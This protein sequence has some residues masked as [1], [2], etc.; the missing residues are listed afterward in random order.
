M[1]AERL[2]PGATLY[3]DCF[4]GLSG[5]MTVAALV[6]LGVPVK[7]VE[8]AVA[9]LALPGVGVRFERVHRGALVGCK[10]RVDLPAAPS[11][12]EAASS[13]HEG[14][15][16]GAHHVGDHDHPTAGPHHHEADGHHPAGG[17]HH[18][19]D[20]P[21]RHYG[22][23]RSLLLGAPLGDGVRRRAL[24]IFDR[25]A[26]VEAHLHG[27]TVDEVAFHEVGALD[28]IVDIVAVAAA[29]DW[30]SPGRVVSRRVPLGHGTVET[31][32]GRLPIPA[33]ATLELLR[34]AAVEDGGV[35][36][37]LVT[38]TGAAILA[39][40]TDEY[41]QLPELTV[42]AVGWGAGD[43]ELADRPNLLR[44]LLGRAG[45]GG[46]ALLQLEANLDDLSPEL[47]APL[48]EALLAAGARDAWLQPVV[49]K[50]GR[51]GWIVGALVDAGHRAAA[52]ELLFRESSTLG[53]RAFP[54]GRT[55]LERRFVEVTTAYGV[56]PIKLAYRL[57]RPGEVYNAAPE[58]EVC[59]RLGAERGVAVKLIY[60]AALA[61]YHAG[62]S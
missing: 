31:A 4:S 46:T 34:G 30:L 20:H 27:T 25:L 61:A 10:L 37:E 41:G 36:A 47:V 38:P 23:I 45:D 11:L 2:S 21:H 51:P 32:H 35:E 48:V 7:V 19:G 15:P 42:S 18:H 8:E 58:F 40:I 14:G 3:I 59:R 62:A 16:T 26:A 28:S 13:P 1:S 29:L 60:L 43:R 54:V 22:E 57:D 24:T 12:D 50:K 53:V 33:P 6:D 17:G 52:E 9:A 56:V 5:D 39:A 49:M 44:L 55:T